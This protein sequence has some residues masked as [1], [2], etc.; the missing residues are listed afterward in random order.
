MRRGQTVIYSEHVAVVGGTIDEI[1]DFVN[2]HYLRGV[3]WY[4]PGRVNKLAGVPRPHLV[5]VLPAA[6][7]DQAAM[8]RL[9]RSEHT[10]ALVEEIK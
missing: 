10:L 7:A 1:E 6:Q 8:A 5:F 4:S 3:P 9:R 2:L